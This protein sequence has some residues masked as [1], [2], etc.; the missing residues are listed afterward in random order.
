VD[1]VSQE[2]SGIRDRLISNRHREV[3]GVN[4]P[5]TDIDNLLI[6][7]DNAKPVAII[8]YKHALAFSK[9]QWAIVE[10]NTRAIATLASWA[11][12]PAFMAYYSIE[13]S[14]FFRYF[15]CALNHVAREWMERKFY[16]HEGQDLCEFDFVDFLYFLR[17][18]KAPNEIMAKLAPSL[19]DKDATDPTHG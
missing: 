12:L 11:N 6:E 18:R 16:F 3:F 17:K 1:G 13:E 7:Y 14:G 15:L 9:H 5:A 4:C 2:R 19:G 10:A 8:E